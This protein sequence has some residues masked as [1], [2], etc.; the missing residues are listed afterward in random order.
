MATQIIY[1]M[2][3]LILFN[4]ILLFA[5]GFTFFFL[6]DD[7]TMSPYESIEYMFLMM[8]GSYNPDDFSNTFLKILFVGAMCIN[9]FFV[10]T[11]LVGLSV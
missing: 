1:R 4:I 2:R 10:F 5:F 8:F 9:V 11:M 7:A 6:S 3:N